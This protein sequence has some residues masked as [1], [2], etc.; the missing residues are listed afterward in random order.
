[1]L[2]TVL[3]DQL[4]VFFKDL[5]NCYTFHITVSP[6]HPKRQELIE[7]LNDIAACSS[8][9]SLLLNEGAGLEF[10][11]YKNEE[12]TRIK[13]RSTPNG[14]EFSSLILAILNCDGKGKNLPDEAI[15]NRIKALKKSIHLKTYVNLTCLTCSELVQMI[16]ALTTYNKQISHEIVDGGINKL[17]V[18][19]LDLE[20]IPTVFANDE[21]FLI[22]RSSFDELTTKLEEKFGFN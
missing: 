4:K 1:M 21:V 5:E 14:H 15:R 19:Q 2:D 8:Q 20:G 12:N 7:I 18:L 22:G 6:E 3:M 17:E 13:F 16:N 9:I 10:S 11:I